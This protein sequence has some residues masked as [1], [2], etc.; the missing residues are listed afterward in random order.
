MW[1]EC[2]KEIVNKQVLFNDQDN[3][4]MTCKECEKIVFADDYYNCIALHCNN[5]WSAD[6]FDALL[7]DKDSQCR[8]CRNIEENDS[9]SECL[10]F[11]CKTEIF[12]LLEVD[13]TRFRKDCTK[14]LDQEYLECLKSETNQSSLSL[15]VYFTAFIMMTVCFML[16]MSK[17]TREEP[18]VYIMIS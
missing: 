9:F 6:S 12:S 14:L 2:R 8:T 13:L 18:Q 5:L 15:W 11:S 17:S 7:I 16:K 10:R 1:K 3:M 4:N